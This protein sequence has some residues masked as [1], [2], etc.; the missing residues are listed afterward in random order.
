LN[1]EA[2]PASLLVLALDSA[3]R[4]EA[5]LVDLQGTVTVVTG[6]RVGVGKALATEAARRGSR[7]II[8]SR[9]DASATVAELKANGAEVD[10]FT[11]D[12]RD[13]ESWTALRE[14][15]VSRFGGVN[16][17]INNAAGGSASG[18]LE[19]ASV[20]G[21]RE[22]IET[23]ILGYIYG[24]KAFAED[25]RASAASGSPAYILNVGSEHSLGVP[26]HVTPLSPYTVSK[27]A[28]LGITEVTRR[29]LAGTGIGVALVAP[30]WVLTETVTGLTEK[31]EGFADAVLPYAQESDLV[32]RVSF[33]GLL[34]GREVIVTNPKSV[35]FAR[36]RAEKLL[37]DYEWAEKRS[38]AG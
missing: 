34:E 2:I 1:D 12:V 38:I 31:S 5:E 7:V 27:Q 22:V 21:I 25:L 26:P 4:E 8:A 11:T 16:I 23:N 36:E 3:I 9:S 32:A 33:D 28:G 13:P 17:L 14:F 15:T 29:D 19:S 6:G 18:S 20:E 10:W 37:A 24:V 30:G 35:A